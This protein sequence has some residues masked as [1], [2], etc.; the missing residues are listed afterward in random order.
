M[1]QGRLP[2]RLKEAVIIPIVKP[3]KPRSNPE[4]YRP[5]LLTS[6]IIKLFER[7][8]K[9]LIQDCLENN[10]K[11]GNFQHGFRKRRS[12]LSQLLLYQ[13]QM[14]RNLEEGGQCDSV[15]LDFAKAF[16]KVDLGIRGFR[17]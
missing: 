6:H 17:L 2:R 14:L 7:I 3:G 10:E 13:D 9:Y 12:C 15:Y 16:D 5:V 4:S 1:Q 11:F 8:L